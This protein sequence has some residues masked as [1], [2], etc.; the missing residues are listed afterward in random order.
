MT[1]K[2]HASTPLADPAAR[3]CFILGMIT[4]F[5]ECVA[6]EC[7]KLALSPPLYPEDCDRVLVEAER[8]AREQGILLWHEKNPDIPEKA[9]LQWL[10]IY[11]FPEVLAGY[12]R[13]RDRGYNPAWD[14]EKFLG[15]LSYGIA[16]GENADRV[17]PGL[18]GEKGTLDSVSRLLLRDGDWPPPRD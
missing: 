15:L 6:N 16:W 11:K 4:A 14:F 17:I 1:R 7:K 18:R 13:L 12:R 10:V 3:T 5:A 2:T 9:R 8:I